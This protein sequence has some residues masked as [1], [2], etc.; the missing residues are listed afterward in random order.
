MLGEMVKGRAAHPAARQ[1]VEEQLL[2]RGIGDT[3]V[4]AAM[5]TLPRHAFVPVPMRREAYEDHAVSI[6]FGRTMAQPCVVGDMA[7]ALTLVGD[8]KVLE[9]G[10]GSGYRAALLGLLAREV[11]TVERVTVL[12]RRARWV[13]RALGI[14]NVHVFIDDGTLGLPAHAPY[15]AILAPDGPPS[16]VAQLAPSGRLVI[17]DGASLRVIR[18]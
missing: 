9:V 16:L 3:R 14:D 6:G 5:A 11:Y 15:D 12:A 7:A 1:M 18:R 4:L 8:E 13:L 10:T 2:A 17:R